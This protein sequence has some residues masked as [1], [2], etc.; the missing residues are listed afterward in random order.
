MSG[1]PAGVASEGQ[2]RGAPRGAQGQEAQGSGAAC[3]W[4]G[5]EGCVGSG[6]AELTTDTDLLAA[7][8]ARVGCSGPDRHL[9]HLTLPTWTGEFLYPL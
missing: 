8:T 4:W 1:S 5:A 7:S 3:I 2:A 9:K 6:E